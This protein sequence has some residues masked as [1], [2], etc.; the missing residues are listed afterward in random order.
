MKI[1]LKGME[2]YAYHG[3]I[4][5]ENL[6][7]QRFVVDLEIESDIPELDDLK[8]TVDYTDIYKKTKDIVENF[9]FK[10]IETLAKEIGKKLLEDKRIKTITVRVEKISPPIK[11]ILEKVGV[12]VILKNDSNIF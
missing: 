2:F 12:E 3:A 4:K 5:E 10:L 1:Y 7:G 11:G 9:K 8:N 6:L